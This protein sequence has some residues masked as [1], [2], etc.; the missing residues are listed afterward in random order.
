[1]TQSVSPLIV[2]LFGAALGLG[3]AF[4]AAPAAAQ[5]TLSTADLMEVCSRTGTAWM[6]FC[7]GYMQSANDIGS[8]LE[9]VCVPADTS[10]MAM[11]ELFRAFAADAIASQP[12]MADAAAINVVVASLNAA[13]PCE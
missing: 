10:R 13:F 11:N 5:M 12:E 2:G 4:S 8:E 7:N 3:A 6:D 1:M 9:L